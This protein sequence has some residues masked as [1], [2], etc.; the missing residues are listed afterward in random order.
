MKRRI[1][2]TIKHKLIIGLSFCALI[3][4]T[5]GCAGIYGQKQINQD[6]ADIYQG[7]VQ[8]LLYISHVRNGINQNLVELNKLLLSHDGKS[9]AAFKASMAQ[10]NTD[11]DRAWNTYY[12]L[13]DSPRERSAADVVAASRKLIDQVTANALS[14]MAQGKFDTDVFASG[15]AYE[16]AFNTAM[17]NADVLYQENKAQA[18]DSFNHA[19]ASFH[20]ILLTT[21][22][23]I[24][25]GFLV[26]LSLLV[27]MIRA[28]SKPLDHAVQLADTIA[29]GHLNHGI[30]VDRS[31][32]VGRLL[33][34][35][36]RMDE[37]FTRIVKE[38]R[39]GAASV[40]TASNQ[41]AQGNDDLSHRT[42][43]QAS[44]LE[45]TA[46]SMEEMNATVRQNAE[47]ASQA[48]Q[49]VKGA[50]EQ[51]EHG[52]KVVSEAVHAMSEIEAASKRIAEISSLIDEIAFQTN[53]LALNAAVEAAR[54]GE[55][56][57]GFAVV[58]GE[59]RTLAQ[60]SASA[61]REIKLLINESSEKVH[62]GTSLVSASGDALR[63]I[64][65]RT[66]KATDVVA[67]IAAASHEQ[68]AGVD[69]VNTTVTALD[70][71]TQ[72]NAALVEEAAAA[73]RAMQ[74]Q[75]TELMQHVNFFRINGAEN[76]EVAHARP[77]SRR[78]GHVASSARPALR[79]VGA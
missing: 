55:E 25:A 68:A 62:A 73:S 79:V 52:G 21:V 50:L 10:N 1:T 31:D 7:D 37:Q 20:R 24:A 32:E 43:E 12:P 36:Q 66:R 53:L 11:M 9:I 75:A 2:F 46:A 28:I 38:V 34:G 23:I 3:M 59:V 61:A 47:N 40:A 74:E 15:G 39:H 63:H 76:E 58:A 71:M 22:G 45:E 65:D 44:S 64:L 42:Q 41:I 78:V 48:S 4:V 67:E 27:V 60:R 70:D 19:E 6:V 51:A 57:R 29:A 16:K 13:I 26:I 77:Q 18:E 33:L 72:R 30:Q 8:P 35:L 14:D 54:A 56:G 17:V 49:L 69:Q 5:I